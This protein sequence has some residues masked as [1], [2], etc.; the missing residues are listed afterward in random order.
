MTVLSQLHDASIF[1]SGMNATAFTSM[2]CSSMVDRNL[3]VVGPAC[4][5]C[6]GAAADEA[7]TSNAVQ[8]MDT[9]ARHAFRMAHPRHL[10]VTAQQAILPV[11]VMD[12][13]TTSTSP[14]I[15]PHHRP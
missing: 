13:T 8:K 3:I 12:Y 7:F 4:P 14:S 6:G 5:G 10:P 9:E 11:R 15:M 1:P 2:S